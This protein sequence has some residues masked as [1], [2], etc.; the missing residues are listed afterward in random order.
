MRRTAAH[1]FPGLQS[2]PV[3]RDEGRKQKGSG[4]QLGWP[5]VRERGA[6]RAGLWPLASAPV[7]TQSRPSGPEDAQ[8]AALDDEAVDGVA[9][10]EGR[11]DRR[12]RAE[13]VGSRRERPQITRWLEAVLTPPAGCVAGARVRVTVDVCGSG[14]ANRCPADYGTVH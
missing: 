13:L 12:G 4:A 3:D 6:E 8:A 5:G 9:G 10:E 2:T 1:L 14:R 7:Q 11:R